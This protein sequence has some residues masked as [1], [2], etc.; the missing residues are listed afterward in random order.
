MPDAQVMTDQHRD[1]ELLMQQLRQGTP[2]ATRR[3]VEEYGEHI[4]RA[5]RRRLCHEMRNQ[6]DSTDFVQD[7]WASFCA[8]PPERYTFEQPADLIR[9]LAGMAGNKVARAYRRRFFTQKTGGNRTRSLDGSAALE[10]LNLAGGEPP[11]SQVVMDREQVERLFRDQPPQAQRILFLLHNG[12]KQQD[13]ARELG[14]NVRTVRRLMEGI[15]S[16]WAALGYEQPPP[17]T[18]EDRGSRIEDRGSRIE[19]RE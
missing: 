6:F 18:A 16:R 7:V 8:V 4:L 10:A 1:F 14:V 9:Y 5:V 13:I 11:Q 2:E 17:W 3:L 15:R 12:Y 19:D